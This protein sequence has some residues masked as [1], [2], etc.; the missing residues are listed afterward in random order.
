ML[1]WGL[2]S[3]S[4]SVDM[5]ALPSFCCLLWQRLFAQVEIRDQW[6]QVVVPLFRVDVF[7][8]HICVET[9]ALKTG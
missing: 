8:K 3:P 6:E 5:G 4:P 2:F 9:D 7:A 1:G